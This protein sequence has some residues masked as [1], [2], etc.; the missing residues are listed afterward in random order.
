MKSLQQSVNDFKKRG[1]KGLDI[2]EKFRLLG[3]ENAPGQESRRQDLEPFSADLS[4]QGEPV[5]FSHGDVD[6]FVPVP[7]SFDMFEMGVKEGAAQAYTEYRG[8]KSIRDDAAAKLSDFTGSPIDPEKNLILTP[9]TQGALFMAAGASIMPGDKVAFVQPDYFAY[10]KLVVFFG[11]ECVPVEMDYMKYT[12]KAGIDLEQLENAFQKGV[13]VFMF[14]NP[15]N[16][17]GVI[18]SAEEIRAIADLS[19]RYHVTLIVDELYSRQIFDGHPYVHLCAL[20]H[21]PESMVTIIGP[22]KTESLSGYRLGTAFGTAALIDRMEELQAIMDL[23]CGGY[24]QAVFR[25]WFDEP[26]DW[27][28][29]RVRQHQVIRDTMAELF[30]KEEG[31]SFRLTEGGSYFFVALP[32]MTVTLDQFIQTARCQAHVTVTPGTEFGP[33]FTHHFRINFSQDPEKA[34][35]AVR[36]LIR[37]VRFY[38]R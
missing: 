36:R 10:R 3:V 18:Y 9:G 12:R 27:M 37:L 1:V 6:A 38:K 33:Q 35:A 32:D 19:A 21:I 11:G 7:G 15:N 23:R 24:N 31:I 14:S 13:K 29:E 22:S 2:I 34:A 28:E 4:L 5:D 25:V 20:D 17:T 16:P 8:R 26:A 30:G